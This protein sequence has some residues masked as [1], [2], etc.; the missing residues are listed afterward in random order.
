MLGVRVPAV[1]SLCGV[2]SDPSLALPGAWLHGI[3]SLQSLALWHKL[4][5]TVVDMFILQDRASC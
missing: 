2:G 1:V 3:Y 4:V 5:E